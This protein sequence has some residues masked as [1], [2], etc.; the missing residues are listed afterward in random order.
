[1]SCESCKSERPIKNIQ[2]GVF[3]FGT[4]LFGAATYGTIELVKN[5]IALIK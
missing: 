2:W 3:L 1:M 5:I 4:Y